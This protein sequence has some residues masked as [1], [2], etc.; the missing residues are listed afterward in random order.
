M[1]TGQG[2]RYLALVRDAFR[3]RSLGWALAAHLRWER[4]RDGRAR[5]RALWHRRPT[6]AVI[7]HAD[8]RGQ[9]SSLACGSRCRRAGITRSMGS[10]GSVGSVGSVGACYDNALAERFLA[11]LACVLSDR[12]R[13]RTPIEA[14]MAVCDCIAR[15][16]NPRRPHSALASL[17]PAAYARRHHPPPAASPIPVHRTGPTPA[18]R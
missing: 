3:R 1:P 7:L 12:R 5:A 16:D 6:T 2:L 13:W 18:G 17:S 8:H 11:T 14:R 10:G 4:V 9:S 15:L